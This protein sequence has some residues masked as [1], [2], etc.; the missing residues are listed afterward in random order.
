MS[1]DFT[2]RA[3]AKKILAC[4]M[5]WEG[6]G[7][8]ST[9]M[10]HFPNFDIYLAGGS[11]RNTILGH[12]QVQDFDFFLAGSEWD[13]AIT[14]LA[15]QGSVKV[16]PLGSPRWTPPSGSAAPCDLVPIQRLNHGLGNCR[17]IIDVLNQ[18]D[19]TGNAI[20]FDLRSQMFF[21]PMGG[22]RD[23]ERRIMRATRFDFPDTPILPNSPVTWRATRWFRILH[24][25]ATLNLI[26]EPITLRWLK[27]NSQY[28]EDREAF[29]EIFFEPCLDLV[30]SG[31]LEQVGV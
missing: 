7:P 29:A 30:D 12:E 4:L 14:Q 6:Y 23:L 16:G 8:I 20:A 17:D 13:R 15:E 28:R 26:I 22:K 9:V 19:F 25:A 10:T 31:L 18:F 2:D 11:V 1:K 24:Y 21:D 5:S 3:L 27:D